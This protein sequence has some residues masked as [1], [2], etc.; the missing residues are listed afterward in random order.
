VKQWLYNGSVFDRGGFAAQR[1]GSYIALIRDP[2]ALVNNPGADRD[3]DRIH[4]PNAELLP[5]EGSP[6]RVIFHLPKRPA[7]TGPGPARL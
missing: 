1:E 3:N 4:F 6:V 7:A 5:P 2:S